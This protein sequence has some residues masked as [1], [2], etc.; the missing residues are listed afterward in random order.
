MSKD[1]IVCLSE[2][3]GKKYHCSNKSCKDKYCEECLIL[4]IQYCSEEK[5]IPVCPSTNCKNTLLLCDLSSLPK[6]I[7]CLYEQCCLDFF[8]KDQGDYVQ[9]QIQ[10]KKIIQQL[11]EERQRFITQTY[12]EAISLIAQISFKSK[13]RQLEKYKKELIEKQLNLSKRH[14]M[15]SVCKGYLDDNLKCM[16]CQTQFCNQCEKRKQDNHQ[17]KREDL[18]SVNIVNN[19]IR[20]PG[21]YLPVFKNEGCNSITCSNCKTNFEYT[22]GHLGGHGSNNAKLNIDLNQRHKLSYS[23]KDHISEQLMPLLLDI[24]HLEPK[25]INKDTLLVLIKEYFETKN[26]IVDDQSM[27]TN[28]AAKKLAKQLERYYLNQ[29][30]VRDYMTYM[31]ELED[32]LI[33]NKITK[34]NM[35]QILKNIKSL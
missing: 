7:I 19:M 28:R 34:D 11:R 9:K 22:T 2:I 25:L 21:C 18:D 23:Y 16:L 26:K 17:C 1:C 35:N 13:L 33:H 31:V 6:D 3:E 20:C 8:L 12:P 27:L 10:E 30:K 15:N 32:L 14:C 4:L 24:E 5:M 29:Y